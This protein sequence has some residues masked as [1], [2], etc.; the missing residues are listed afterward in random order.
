VSKPGNQG[1]LAVLS[2]RADKEQYRDPGNNRLAFL[3]G[4]GWE[5]IL[6]VDTSKMHED[7]DDTQDHGQVA[8]AVHD[9]RLVCGVVVVVILNPKADQQVVTNTHP[10]PSHEHK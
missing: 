9:E 5:D 10:F 7:E 6:I 1:Y 2:H 8:D 3:Q 4:S